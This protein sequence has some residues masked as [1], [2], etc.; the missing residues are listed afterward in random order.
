[1][2]LAKSEVALDLIKFTLHWKRQPLAANDFLTAVAGIAEVHRVTANMEPSG[3]GSPGGQGK[4]PWGS[5][6]QSWS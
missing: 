4:P 2:M 5:G 1:M 3:L 6:M